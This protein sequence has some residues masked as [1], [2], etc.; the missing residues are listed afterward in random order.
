MSGRL[1]RHH[2]GGRGPEPG[3]TDIGGASNRGKLQ[4]AKPGRQPESPCA[5]QRGHDL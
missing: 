3:L 5:T 4:R 1:V 2:A